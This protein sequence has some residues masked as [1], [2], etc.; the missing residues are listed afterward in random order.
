MA[1][2]S[3]TSARSS[4][5]RRQPAAFRLRCSKRY[6]DVS[7][8]SR[9][10]F[11]FF[12]F[13]S[14]PPPPPLL[15][16]SLAVHCSSS[17]WAAKSPDTWGFTYSL[18]AVDDA[19]KALSGGAGGIRTRGGL[20]TLT[21]FPGV[22]LK[23]LIHRSGS[24]AILA[25]RAAAGARVLPACTMLMADAISAAISVMLL[26]TIRVVVASAATLP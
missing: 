22:R 24:A 5:L 19:A 10:F 11:F 23:P 16:V 17:G 15:D 25:N 18:A 4:K 9:F 13:F 3:V 20:L 2:I 14:P 7:S 21:R 6:A 26:G 1:A 12:F 8:S